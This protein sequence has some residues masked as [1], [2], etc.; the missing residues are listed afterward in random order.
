M[1]ALSLLLVCLNLLVSST[2]STGHAEDRLLPSGQGH[3][4]V[5]AIDPVGEE[6]AVYDHDTSKNFDSVA[7]AWSK[8]TAR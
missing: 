5:G 4:A 3:H 6:R 7:A 2:V 8:L 1:V